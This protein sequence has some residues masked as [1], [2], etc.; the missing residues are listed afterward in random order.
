MPEAYYCRKSVENS[1][2]QMAETIVNTGFLPLQR[3]FDVADEKI[4]SNRK[5]FFFTEYN[6]FSICEI[7]SSPII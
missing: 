3:H 5:F 4:E 1:S 2:A 7:Q 6:K